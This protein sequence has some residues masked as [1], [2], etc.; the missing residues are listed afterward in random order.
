MNAVLESPKKGKE[1]GKEEGKI[2]IQNVNN[3]FN[4][5]FDY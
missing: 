1:K 3:I 4:Q 2:K 5:N